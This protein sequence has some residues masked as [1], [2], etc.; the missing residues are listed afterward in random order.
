MPTRLSIIHTNRA[1]SATLS[2][3]P[4][5]NASYPVANLKT[6]ARTETLR[7]S[8]LTAQQIRAVWPANVSANAIALCY[9]DLTAAATWRVRLYSDATFTTSVYDSGTVTAYDSGGISSF[10]D[11]NSAAFRE[12]KN[13]VLWLTSTFTNVRSATIDLNDSTNPDGF[14]EAARLFIGQYTELQRN[15]KWL[16]PIALVSPTT[17]QTTLGGDDLGQ[18]NGPM[19]RK[20]ELDMSAVLTE[21]DRNFL[22]D[23]VRVKDKSGD[24]F[25]SA[26]PNAGGKITRD[27]AMWARFVDWQ[28]VD[29][30]MINL[31]GTKITA[32]SR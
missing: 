4:A 29:R 21:A 32:G 28:G 1:D 8:G 16:H 15:F 10:D 2:V 25:L 6:I 9:H 14:L 23:L 5:E 30:P 20:L 26:W 19:K 3:S 13:S 12:Y 22:F 18:F 31:Y 24:F 11:I 7:T 17:M 27:Y